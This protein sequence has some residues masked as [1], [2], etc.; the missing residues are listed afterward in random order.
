[1]QAWMVRINLSKWFLPIE[2]GNAN[3]NGGNQSEEVPA[4]ESAMLLLSLLTMLLIPVNN[5]LALMLLLNSQLSNLKSAS[6]FPL[7]I[8][9]L[10]NVKSAKLVPI[11]TILRSKLA[12]L[13]CLENQSEQK[14]AIF[15]II[16]SENQTA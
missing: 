5:K 14:D 4:I 1:M 13:K 9:M 16:K 10:V 11:P 12:V 6:L 7:L 8:L 3:L 2:S 15:N